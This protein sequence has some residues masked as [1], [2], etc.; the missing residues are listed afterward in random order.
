VSLDVLQS[1]SGYLESVTCGERLH[2]YS[3]FLA[4][5]SL[6]CPYSK[7][8]RCKVVTLVQH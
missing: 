1:R 3:Y 8:T 7:V 6:L 4:E 5:M 2:L